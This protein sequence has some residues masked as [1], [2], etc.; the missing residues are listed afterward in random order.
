MPTTSSLRD[1]RNLGRA[2]TNAGSRDWQEAVRSDIQHVATN[3]SAFPRRFDRVIGLSFGGIVLG[4][5]GCIL[6]ASMPYRHPVGITISMLWWGIYFGCF[7]MWLGAVLGASVE[8][9]RAR[10][11]QKSRA[12]ADKLD[13]ARPTGVTTTRS[14]RTGPVHAAPFRSKQYAIPISTQ[15]LA[16][17]AS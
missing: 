15:S 6:G 3:S 13:Y 16:E 10:L 9:I 7:G 12:K 17:E 1:L 4:T 8:R 14:Q 2:P 5:G 11:S